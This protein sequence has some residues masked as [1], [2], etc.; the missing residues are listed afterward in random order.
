MTPP[1]VGALGIPGSLVQFPAEPPPRA[2]KLGLPV[3]AAPL[4]AGLFDPGDPPPTAPAGAPPPT[5]PAGGPPP[6]A[7]L[8]MP[9]A[10]TPPPTTPPRPPPPPA[11][12][13]SIG[14][15]ANNRTKPKLLGLQI[16]MTRSF[17]FLGHLLQSVSTLLQMTQSALSEAVHAVCAV[18]TTPQSGLLPQCR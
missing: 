7:A 10:P 15:A 3:P 11:N 12:A 13:N 17:Q 18:P 14:S 16:I 6:T 2:F 1:M 8:P 9:A 5:A 4:P